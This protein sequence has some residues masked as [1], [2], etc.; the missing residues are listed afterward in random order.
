MSCGAGKGATSFGVGN[1]VSPGSSCEL[2]GGQRRVGEVG[3]ELRGRQRRAVE[4]PKVAMNC[5]A[6]SDV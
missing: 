2:R 3:C 6:S 4:V 1:E 5:G